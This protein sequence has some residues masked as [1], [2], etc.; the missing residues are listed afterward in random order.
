[1]QIS[2]AVINPQLYNEKVDLKKWKLPERKQ[3]EQSPHQHKQDLH[4][5]QHKS[6]DSNYQFP[7]ST[8]SKLFYKNTHYHLKFVG[9]W[10]THTLYIWCR[11][12]Y[13]LIWAL[14]TDN[15]KGK[16]AV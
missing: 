3:E 1:M 9:V 5:L 14:K 8:F 7:N 13:V 6:L 12:V 4:S 15:G 11:V 10:Y 16:V 2:N